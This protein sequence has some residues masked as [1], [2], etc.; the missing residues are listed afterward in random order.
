MVKILLNSLIN[1]EPGSCYNRFKG[2]MKTAQIYMVQIKVQVDFFTAE[3]ARAELTC[4]LTTIT[5]QFYQLLT[6]L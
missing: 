3:P 6:E 4:P 5:L 2:E 1:E